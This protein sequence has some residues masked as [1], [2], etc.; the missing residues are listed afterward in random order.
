MDDVVDGSVGSGPPIASRRSAQSSAVR[1]SGPT[2]SYVQET[3]IT[4][5]FGTRPVVGRIPVTPQSAAGMR[6]EPAVSVPS[7]PGTRPAATAAPLP[8]LDPPQI[9]S[10]SHGLRA[11]PNASLVVEAPQANSCV[12]SL[13]TT[14][15]P[16]RRRRATTVASAVATLSASTFDAAVVRVPATSIT[17]LTAIGTPCSG[18]VRSGSASASASASSARTVMNELRA[19]SSRS[20]RSSAS[21]TASR[22][23]SSPRRIAAASADSVTSPPG[24]G[25]TSRGRDV[26]ARPLLELA[27]GREHRG[28]EAEHALEVRVGRLDPLDAGQRAELVEGG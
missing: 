6:T 2:V 16:A 11:G 5:R 12:L 20:I 17:S 19:P 15:A 26:A 27:Q 18:P 1:A 9:R 13:P 28:E 21:C 24:R 8:P 4:P 23:E 10:V 25:G 22:G 14:T 7:A 3:G